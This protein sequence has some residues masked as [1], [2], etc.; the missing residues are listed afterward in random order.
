MANKLYTTPI[1]R[2][3]YCWLQDDGYAYKG[4]KAYL[5]SELIF[6][7]AD[8]E[9][10][11]RM[12]DE[13]IAEL[14]PLEGGPDT[15][16]GLVH[17]VYKEEANGEFVLKTKRP[18]LAKDAEGI[19]RQQRVA[20]LNPD[21]T[22]FEGEVG[23]GSTVEMAI[24]YRAWSYGGVQGLSARPMA[25]RVYQAAKGSYTKVKRSDEEWG[26]YFGEPGDGAQAPETAD[27]DPAAEI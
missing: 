12:T 16:E 6:S 1:A 11:K 15:H 7:G 27:G 20:I 26:N 19:E 17:K 5:K 13:A 23:S 21:N 4:G 22:P 24:E 3:R 18:L 2:T 14:V 10:V 9:A 25:V 8:G